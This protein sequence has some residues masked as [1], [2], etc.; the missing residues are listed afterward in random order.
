MDRWQTELELAGG[1][2]FTVL[3]I[4]TAGKKF[5]I[6]LVFFLQSLQM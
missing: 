2:G 4:K 6:F 3:Q 1:V 5:E